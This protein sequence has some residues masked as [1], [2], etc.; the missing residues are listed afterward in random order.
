[1]SKYFDYV[2]QLKHFVEESTQV[3]HGGVQAMHEVPLK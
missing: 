3:P 1:L 2:L